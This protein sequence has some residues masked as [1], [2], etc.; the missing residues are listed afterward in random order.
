ML[1]AREMKVSW[2]PRLFA[3]RAWMTDFKYSL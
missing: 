2:Q 3:H 1:A